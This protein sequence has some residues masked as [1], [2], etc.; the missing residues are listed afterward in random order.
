MIKKI[1]KIL[2]IVFLIVILL[3]FYLSFFGIKTEKFNK[4]INNSILKINKEIN[5]SLGDVNYLLNLK[6]FSI[7]IETKNP[8]IILED[9]N[10]EIKSIQT[11]VAL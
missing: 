10:L 1:S 3:I 2:L 5:L 8:Q 11:T 7:N 4:Q 6:N 9:R